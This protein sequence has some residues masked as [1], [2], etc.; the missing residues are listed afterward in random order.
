MKYHIIVLLVLLSGCHAH[1]HV[2]PAEDSPFVT[3]LAD[4][5]VLRVVATTRDEAPD[6]QVRWAE[7]APLGGPRRSPQP[8]NRTSTKEQSELSDGWDRRHLN[9]LY[10]RLFRVEHRLTDQGKR[11]I[12]L[13]E[14]VSEVEFP[15]PLGEKTK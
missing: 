8:A 1:T 5:P 11:L 10:W 4:S 7:D 2:P 15:N 6:Q 12:K 14:R 3:A 13:D 9:S